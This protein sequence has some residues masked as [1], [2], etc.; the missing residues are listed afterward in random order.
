MQGGAG[1]WVGWS[2]GGVGSGVGVRVGAGLAG[3]QGGAG[4][5][6]GW[7][8]GGAGSAGC[9]SCTCGVQ[10]VTGGVRGVQRVRGPGAPKKHLNLELILF[11]D[12]RSG[13][14]TKYRLL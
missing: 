13:T 12:R 4:A 6:V 11:D 14:E 1:V 2:A 3:V 5:W 10:G 8:D 7:S 9:G